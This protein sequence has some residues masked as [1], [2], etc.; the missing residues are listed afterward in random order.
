MH[1][2]KD[3]LLLV[4]IALVLGTLTSMLLRRRRLKWT[5]GICG[6]PLGYLLWNLGGGVL[7]LG[8]A[9]A[10][11]LSCLLGYGWHRSELDWGAD[12]AER[13]RRRTGIRELL[14]LALRRLTARP[15]PWI[16]PAGLEVGRDERGEPATIPLGTSSGIHTLVLGA[17][18]AGKTVTETWIACRLIEAGHGAIAIDPKGDRLMRAELKRA[19][20]AQQ[21]RFVEWTPEGPAAYNPY[22][23]GS[24]GE[25]ADKALAGEQFTEPHYLRQAQRYIGHAVRTMRAAGIA[26]TPVT[27]A[28]HM[29]PGRLESAS[30]KLE[31]AQ[32]ELLQEYLDSLGERQRR[33]LAGVRDRL[34]IIAES[35]TA[36]WL[37]P[38]AG[39]PALDLL[40]AVQERAVV[41]MRLDADRR[42]LLSGMLGAAIV[43][44]LVTI[45]AAIQHDPAPTVV[46]LD[47]FAAL[48]ARQI[49]RLF[50]RGRS[51]GISLVLGTQELADLQAAGEQLRDQVLGNVEALI[52]HRQNVP[53]SA[54]L[55]AQLAGSRPAWITTQQ[56]EQGLLGSR[57]GS[58][59]SKT[60]GHEF[61]LHPSRI[62]R[63]GR[64]RA[65][66]ITPGREGHPT[67]A[68]IHHPSS[69]HHDAE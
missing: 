30:R 46:V 69:A 50:G 40:A 19:A 1:A 44:D 21:R 31:P 13:A 51:A 66:V 26:V 4:T 39:K 35:E 5:W 61:E 34:A 33:E 17:T 20:A 32:A 23:H 62:K 37:Q 10:A 57:A 67:I 9:G 28:A 27:L 6:L 42:M 41:Y 16:T 8:V 2:L 52:A 55:V 11:L 43:G 53:E 48:G 14:A 56:T 45:A 63:L 12:I 60:R 64:G 24:D 7:A 65:A 47:E 15:R 22:A 36:P 29:D 59:G 58:R 68:H 25:I 49:A 3:L 54:E 38:S 18:G